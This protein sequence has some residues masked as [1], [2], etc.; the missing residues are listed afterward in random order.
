MSSQRQSRPKWLLRSV[1]GLFAACLALLLA[2]VG[3]LPEARLP[4][5]QRV[6]AGLARHGGR[7][8]HRATV[9]LV[10]TSFVAAVLA[11]PLSP[12]PSAVAA[13]Q[14]AVTAL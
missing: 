7:A 9:G 10:L 8:I 12:L 6:R 13:G 2:A 5:W 11:A 14:P 4:A 1:A 3:V